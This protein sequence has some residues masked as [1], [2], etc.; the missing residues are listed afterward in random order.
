MNQN[1]TTH[2]T[3]KQFTYWPDSS[4]N[5]FQNSHAGKFHSIPSPLMQSAADCDNWFLVQKCAVLPAVEC[6][7][8]PMVFSASR[9]HLLEEFSVH[10]PRQTA[11]RG[12]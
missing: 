8:G 4:W 2:V 7:R 1:A 11:P 6:N 9:G 12:N 5:V 10:L 3:L